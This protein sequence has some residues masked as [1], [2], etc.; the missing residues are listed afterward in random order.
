MFNQGLPNYALLF[1]YIFKLCRYREYLVDFQI[2]IVNVASY[3]KYCIL[4]VLKVEYWLAESVTN[5]IETCDAVMNDFA[6]LRRCYSWVNFVKGT[7]TPTE[8]KHEIAADESWRLYYGSWQ[9]YA[10]GK[11]PEMLL[12]LKTRLLKTCLLRLL[13]GTLSPRQ[14]SAP[15]CCQNVFSSIVFDQI[16]GQD[17]FKNYNVDHTRFPPCGPNCFMLFWILLKHCQQ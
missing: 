10:T 13:L 4:L 8:W 9:L 7:E 5:Q 16:F 6:K 12:Q 17:A 15:T 2:K 1:L 3:L 11:V 14:K